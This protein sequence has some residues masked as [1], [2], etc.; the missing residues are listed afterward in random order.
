MS[1]E[2]ISKVNNIESIDNF[3]EIID[4]CESSTAIIE[5]NKDIK[6]LTTL[7]IACENNSKRKVCYHDIDM[8]VTTL[9]Q[10][11]KDHVGVMVSNQGYS[12]NANEKGNEF[13][14]MMCKTDNLIKKLMN[15]I[16]ALKKEIEN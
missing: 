13:R 10:S 9:Q 4:S 8:F 11:Y 16:D 12:D 3:E 15:H 2:N 1:K 6:E 14:I 5:T 7:E